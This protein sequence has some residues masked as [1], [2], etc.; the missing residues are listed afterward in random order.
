MHANFNGYRFSSF[1][2]GA[3][4]MYP[5][6]YH[7]LN[8]FLVLFQASMLEPLNRAVQDQL[9]I[10]KEKERKHDEKMSRAL[11]AMFGRKV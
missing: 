7:Y 5:L 1:P 2:Q 4:G 8:M 9:R 6:I 10:L 3:G 11:G